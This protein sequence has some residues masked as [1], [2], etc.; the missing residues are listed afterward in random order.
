MSKTSIAIL[1]TGILSIFL[2]S[3]PT[4]SVISLMRKIR[5]GEIQAKI[6]KPIIVE[7]FFHVCKTNGKEKAQ[8]SIMNLLK[9]YPIDLIEFTP[10]LL[11]AA[12][13]LKCQH[14]THLSYNDCMSIALALDLKAIFH[15][16]EKRLKEI[17]NNVL[18][19]LKVVSYTF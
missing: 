19:R 11:L 16:T 13:V 4:P 2:S 18:N 10:S 8:I 17:P 1:D 5:K 9:H 15:T 7:T 14:R 6:P 3:N 12:G